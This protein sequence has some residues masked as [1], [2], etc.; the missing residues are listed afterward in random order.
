MPLIAV[1]TGSTQGIG[2]S[3]A[4][5]FVQDGF[6]VLAIARTRSKL[7]ALA[8]EI[9]AVEPYVCDVSQPHEVETLGKKIAEKYSCIDVLINNAGIGYSEPIE[10]TTW[11]HWN[12][13]LQTNLTGPFLMTK[14]ALP[15]LEKSER[16]HVF[17]I[18]STASRRGFAHS[19][20]YCASK[21]GLLGLTEVTRLE[22][23][24]RGVRVTAVIPGAVHTPFWDGYAAGFDRSVMLDPHDVAVAIRDAYRQPANAVVEEILIKPACGDL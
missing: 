21:F 5:V 16:P 9:E 17:N 8:K 22:L 1:I 12:E 7:E 6:H 3:L 20:S 11:E 19:S 10:A 15:L 18:C 13:V 4:E 2:K 24:P 23:R 14:M